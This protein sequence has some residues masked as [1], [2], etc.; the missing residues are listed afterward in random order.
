MCMNIRG[1]A[2]NMNCPKVRGKEN[3]N[4]G[5]IP[6]RNSL[7]ILQKV[8]QGCKGGGV[9][10]FRE[11]SRDADSTRR[12]TLA[13]F[14]ARVRERHTRLGSLDWA[15]RR[16]RSDELIGLK[17]FWMKASLP[18]SLNE[19]KRIKEFAT[20]GDA[21]DW[22]RGLSHAKRTRYHCATSPL[23]KRE[24]DSPFKFLIDKEWLHLLFSLS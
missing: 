14:V 7:P 23:M 13:N 22:T 17:C 3:V 15:T 16:K 8:H 12:D 5:R 18:L 24:S 20:V 11:Y 19:R 6:C 2:G 1:V 10:L 21:G 9:L 4:E